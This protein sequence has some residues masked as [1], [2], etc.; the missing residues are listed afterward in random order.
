MHVEHADTQALADAVTLLRAQFGE[1]EIALP[2]ETL[3]EAVLTMLREPARGAI[4]LA[5]DEDAA[6]AIAVLA[7]SWT[8]EHGG[9]IAWLDELYVEPARRGRG[10]GGAL[11]ARALEVAEGAGCRAMELEVDVE[12][13]RAEHLYER[14]GFAAL[15]RRRWSKRLHAPES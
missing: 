11:L 4:L 9:L 3:E 12:H 1:H 13:R 14:A 5:R 7:Y 10:I 6:V 15:A 2:D 8:L